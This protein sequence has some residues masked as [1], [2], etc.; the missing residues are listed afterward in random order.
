MAE[1]ARSFAT[2]LSYAAVWHEP[3]HEKSGPAQSRVGRG[4][5]DPYR[6]RGARAGPRA[7][8]GAER[9]AG[10]VRRFGLLVWA[11][12]VSAR[13]RRVAVSSDCTSWRRG[14]TTAPA[15]ACA[16]GRRRSRPIARTRTSSR[17]S[18]SGRLCCCTTCC[19]GA[20]R[21]SR[22]E[23]VHRRGEC[24]DRGAR[25]A[26]DGRGAPP[27]DRSADRA[28]TRLRALLV[29]VLLC[30]AEGLHRSVYY[31]VAV[32]AAFLSWVGGLAFAPLSRSL[33]LIRA[34][35]DALI[36]LLGKPIAES[37]ALC[38]PTALSSSSTTAGPRCTPPKTCRRDHPAQHPGA[39]RAR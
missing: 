11:L 23:R 36:E 10:R 31:G 15:L 35:G 30:L 3:S 16:R 37:D 20:R 18:G 22:R 39:G 33:G 8:D 12:V 26:G 4:R 6:A 9:G 17:S 21:R 2:D 25:A 38:I 14:R 5:A 28:G 13:R 24:S 34:G 29:L 27:T 7:R 19:R 32:I 1:P